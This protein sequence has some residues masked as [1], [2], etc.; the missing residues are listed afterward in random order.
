MAY[1][2]YNIMAVQGVVFHKGFTVL[3]LNDT[4]V[5]KHLCTYRNIILYI[6]Y[7]KFVVY[8]KMTKV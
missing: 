4:I 8:K 6:K 1:N 2:G 3:V 7:T 5:I